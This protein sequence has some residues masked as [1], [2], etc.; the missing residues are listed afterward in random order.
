MASISTAPSPPNR[1]PLTIIYSSA[2]GTAHDLAQRIARLSLRHHFPVD[3]LPFDSRFNPTTLAQLPG[4]VIFLIATA[5]NGS[6]PSMTE[7]SWQALLS[8]QLHLGRTLNAMQFAIFG[9]G[10]SSYP[11]FCW[12]ERMLRKRLLDLGAKEVAEKGEGDEQHYLGIEGTFQPF[13]KT[14][15]ESLDDTYPLEQGLSVLEDDVPLP[16]ALELRFLDEA[17]G[18]Q[19]P[20]GSGPSHHLN[21][22]ISSQLNG[23]STSHQLNG[24]SSSSSADTIRWLKLTKNQRLTSSSHWQD[25]RLLELQLPKPDEP[26]L[27]Y[28]AGDVAALRP[29]NDPE[30]VDA[31][32]HRMGWYQHRDRPVGLFNRKGEQV[33]LPATSPPHSSSPTQLTLFTYLQHHTSPFS[34]LRPSLFPLLRPFSPRD[35]IEHEKLTEFSTPGDG[36]EDAMDYGVKTRRTIA[37]VLDEFKSVQFEPRYAPEI[38]AGGSAEGGMREREFSI[39]SSP[40][41]NP[42]MIKL[43]VAIVEYKTRIKEPRRGVATRWIAN[44]DEQEDVLIPVTLR[45]STLLRL[46]SNESTPIIAVGPGTGMAPIRG[47]IHERLHNCTDA[48]GQMMVFL[49]CRSY[50]HQD[51]LLHE[52]WAALAQSHPHHLSVHWASSRTDPTQDH[53]ERPNGSKEYVQDLITKQSSAVWELLAQGAYIYISGSSG[54]MPTQVR[55]AFET[56][57][58]Q[59]AGLEQDQAVR[60]VDRL[61]ATGRWREECWS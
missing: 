48:T 31:L 49:G 38:F 11:R 1:P 53:K 3:V 12:P 54:S 14:L 33:I 46:P 57:V 4:P 5:G 20:N 39:A 60:F 44:L 41:E 59:E 51:A 55:K 28:V 42:R 21:G 43:V 16:P 47:L 19:H 58:V 18:I 23:N 40:S 13:L 56:V 2:T 22:T 6:F 10:D 36:Y 52:E 50:P 7:S 25:V 26:D 15:F 8:T 34:P 45:S 17:N 29:S 32:L 30:M 24:S 27:Q 35:H 37:E 9:L 61:E